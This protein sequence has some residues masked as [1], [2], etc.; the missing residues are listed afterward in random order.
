MK[1]KNLVD[2]QEELRSQETTVSH[3]VDYYLNNIE[4]SKELNIYVEVFADEARRKAKDLD[5]KIKNGEQLGSLHGAVISIKDV[6]CYKDHKV[7]AG[8]KI[9]AGFTSQ[10]TSTALQ[11]LLDEDAIVIGRTNCDEFAMGSSNEN[12]TYGVTKNGVDPTRIAG[13]SSGGAAVSVQRDTCLIALGTDT[14]GSVRQPAAF[15]GL[16]GMKPSY[17]RIS[18]YG[19]VAYGSSFDQIGA[20][21]QGL[22][23]VGQFIHAMSG[24]DKMDSTSSSKPVKTDVP[25]KSSYSFAYIDEVMNHPKMDTSIRDAAQEMLNT[26]TSSGHNVNKVTFPLLKYL[27]PAYYVLTTA[28]ASSNLGRYDGIRYGHRSDKADSIANV[29]QQ[30][31]NEGF[32]KEVK[33]RIMLGTF[34][35][36]SGYYDAYY[37]KAQK[38]RRLVTE[39][40]TSILNDND[41]LIIPTSTSIAWP[42]GAMDNDPVAVYLSDIFTVIANLTGIPALSIPLGQDDSGN[43]FGIQLMSRSYTEAQLLELGKVAQNTLNN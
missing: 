24:R 21:G 17:G 26:L 31:R 3:V 39:A 9:L 5:L 37:T 1:G 32:G 25:Q 14:G 33:R 43:P 29:Y 4:A 23:D 13:G 15:N 16:V 18:R 27:V 38:V 28:E 35:L 34:V 22:D 8:S 6:I 20:I 42:I 12:S 30:T 7:T 2:I 36:S 41:C 40:I 19:V 11:K 10:F